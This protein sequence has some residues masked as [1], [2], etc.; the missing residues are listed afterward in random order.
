[1]DTEEVGGFKKF[2]WSQQN[3]NPNTSTGGQ[4]S[5]NNSFRK[6]EPAGL[7][8]SGKSPNRNDLFQSKFD[9]IFNEDR[10]DSNENG[11]ALSGKNQKE[12]V[13]SKGNFDMP[14]LSYDAIKTK[15]LDKV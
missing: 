8:R 7:G 1:M 5:G 3:I 14:M 9:Y 6:S 15:T 4:A 10:Q 12:R 11:G 13:S 2:D